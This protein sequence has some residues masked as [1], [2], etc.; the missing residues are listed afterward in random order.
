MLRDPGQEAVIRE[1]LARPRR[2]ALY[3]MSANP[4]RPSYFVGSYLA[5]HGFDFVSINPGVKAIF[6]H[7][8]YPKLSDV[9]GGPEVAVIFR[10]AEECPG[11]VREAVAAGAKYVWLQFGL[12]SEE[13]R[14]IAAEARVGYVE[15][16]CLK[17][18]HS[19]YLGN[20]YQAGINTGLI[21]ARRRKG[22][23]SGQEAV[24]VA[25]VCRL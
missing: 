24:S 5:G 14:Q 2:Y 19:R 7:P 16:R 13:S 22:A 12:V 18:E 3:G 21:S 4:V 25:A 8:C 1:I 23:S 6:G 9:P 11:V 15:D 17:V 10:R 20:L